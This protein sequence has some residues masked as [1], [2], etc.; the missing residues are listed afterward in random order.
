[1]GLIQS[2]K[3]ALK[4]LAYV[5][6]SEQNAR[7]HLVIA[8]LVF[9]LGLLLNLSVIQLSVILFAIVIVFLA[10]II[11]T[12]FEKILDIIDDKRNIKIELIKDMAAGA[13]LI[14]SITAF[15]VGVI[16]LIPRFVEIIWPLI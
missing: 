8:V 3:Y 4:G 7:I 5:L 9:V 1:M 11:N 13:V 12:A 2:F 15:I 16:V 14:A 10:E 6:K